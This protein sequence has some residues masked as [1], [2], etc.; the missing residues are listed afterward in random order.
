MLMIVS[1]VSTSTYEEPMCKLLVRYPE[2][3]LPAQTTLSQPFNAS[4]ADNSTNIG[5]F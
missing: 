3:D 1:H 2:I 4:I 5:I